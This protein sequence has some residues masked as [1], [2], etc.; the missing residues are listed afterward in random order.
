MGVFDI[1]TALLLLGQDGVDPVDA[2]GLSF[3]VPN[4][5][6]SLSKEALQL[7]PGDILTDVSDSILS[8]R[9]KA[10]EVV[11]DVKK[12]L[13]LEN[14]IIEIDAE[15]GTFKFISDS[16]K[17]GLDKKSEGI[18]A[19][20]GGVTNLFGEAIGFG[21]EIYENY[22]DTLS[23]IEGVKGC[24]DSYQNWLKLQKGTSSKTN[25]QLAPTSDPLAKFETEKAKIEVAIDF[26]DTANNQL[27]VIEEI[28]IAKANG[29][30]EEPI[31]LDNPLLSAT[32]VL[33]ASAVQ[34]EKDEEALKTDPIFDL[35]FG[36][37]QSKSG[38]FLL[39]VDGLY[40]DSQSGGLPEVSGFVPPEEVWKL[41]HDPNLGGKGKPISIKSFSKFFDTIFDLD[42]IDNSKSMQK[43]YDEDHFLQVLK[44]Q[45]NKQVYDLSSFVGDLITSGY[46]S[47]SAMVT[48][49]RQSLYSNI[50]IHEDKINR[51]KKQ[52]EVAV[53]APTLLGKEINFP[54]GE[55]PINDFSYLG[56]ANFA[57]ALEKQQKLV[58]KVGE[59]S[60]IVLPLQPK[61]VTAQEAEGVA[62]L[63]HLVVPDVG[64]GGIIFGSQHG[65][66]TTAN[67]LSLTDH[68]ETDGLIAI[69]NFLQSDVQKPNNCIS[70]LL[71]CMNPAG[72]GNAA[73]FGNYS[74][75][76]FTSGLAIPFLKGITVPNKTSPTP[77]GLGSFVMLPDTKE[78]Q[79]LGYGPKGFSVDFWMHIPQ[80]E[81]STGAPTNHLDHRGWGASSLYKLVLANEN[82][83]A[84]G[85]GINQFKALYDDGSQVVRGMVMGFTR[86]QQILSGLHSD[87]TASSHP[88][89]SL[90]FFMAPTRSINTSDV[91][92][93]NSDE[94][95]VGF[96]AH[97]IGIGTRTYVNGKRFNDVSSGFHHTVLTVD[98]PKNKVSIYLDGVEMATSTIPETFGSPAYKPP[99]IPSFKT[100]G[101]FEYNLSST[102]LEV[103]KDGP[104]MHPYFTPWIVGGG[105]TDGMITKG[106]FMG[107]GR[108]TKSGLGGY[109]G[110]LKFYNKALSIDE[111][112]KNYKAQKGFFDNIEI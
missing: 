2:V 110:S 78:F 108:G 98:P 29:E 94:C 33:T 112:N 73:L 107:N 105:W 68:I 20:L 65:S 66:G 53:K 46:A 5:L 81:A 4:C 9:E 80:L 93:I 76:V 28:Q 16:S 10:K 52:I 8:G 44:G 31:F 103:F 55:V 14:G 58:F 3:G 95:G 88:V 92:F 43:H 96:R 18:L 36:P 111:V 72:A 49:F 84:G 1:E 37:P 109:I 45:K 47:D 42:K 6:L 35:V 27:A 82:I 85:S 64:A 62:E 60:G 86:D 102:N 59:V 25:K 71:N 104:K 57:V 74:S 40:Y 89:S 38:Q 99:G 63:D 90:K 79:D 87:N 26:I 7:L 91:T 19:N 39:S 15:S 75:A 32:T 100:S 61:F 48:N 34:K 41:E 70:N 83:G 21:A 11:S 23:V 67:V 30:L 54:K 77:S 50:A 101:S 13:L 22:K 106:Q 69:Y 56:N 17:F 12:K 51:R 97:Q 24:I